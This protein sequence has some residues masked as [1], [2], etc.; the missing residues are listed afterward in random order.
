MGKTRYLR[1]NSKLPPELYTVKYVI[2]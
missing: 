1:L 2:D